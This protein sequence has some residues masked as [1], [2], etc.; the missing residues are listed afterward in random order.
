LFV[1]CCL[2]FV[3]AAAV[4]VA[5]CFFSDHFSSVQDPLLP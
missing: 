3:V 2:L 4:A 5:V 1:V